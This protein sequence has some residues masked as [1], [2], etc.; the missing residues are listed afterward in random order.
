MRN[1]ASLLLCILVTQIGN[2]QIITTDPAIPIASESA[3]VYYD[4][5]LGTAG[6]KGF[7]GD[8]Y[9][10]TGVLTEASNDT[11]DWKYAPSWGD[12]APK[13]KLTRISTDYYS[14]QI[15]P[16]IREYYGVPENETITHMA[17]VFRSGDTSLEGKDDGGADIFV[18]VFEPGFN[19]SIVTP[20]KSLLVDPGTQVQFEAVASESADLELFMNDQSVKS[21]TG[22][23]ITNTFDFTT[24]GDYWLKVTATAAD[25]TDADSV[26]IHVLGSQVEQLLPEGSENGINY[27]D[28]QTVR[29]VLHAPGKENVFVIGDFN[30]WTPRSDAR[31]LRDNEHWWITLNDLEPGKEYAFQYLVDGAFRIADPYTEKVLDPWNDGWISNETYPDLKPYPSQ[32]T[33]GVTSVLQTGQTAYTW[34]NTGFIPPAKENLVIY[35]LLV[36]DFIGA[37]D[38]NTLTDTLNYFSKL[39]VNAIELMPVNEFEG[40]ESWGYNPAFYF[41]PDKYYGPAEDLKVFIDSCHGR[42]IAVIL[43]MTLNH[44]YGLSPLVQLYLNRDTYKVTPENPW[45]NVDSPNQTYSW[46][47]DF[48][49]ES[50]A[51][52]AFVDRVNHHW[53]TSYNVDG[54]RFDFTKGFTNTPGDGWAY[55]ASRISLLRRMADEIWQVNNEAY[56]IL[57]HL[58]DNSEETV[59]SND[60]MLLWGNLNYNYSQAS[61]GYNV[62]NASDFGWISYKN[63]GW[64]DPH[65]VGYMESH[66]EERMM[67]RNLENGNASGSYDVTDIFTALDRI[68]LSAAFFFTIPGPKMIW[69]FGEVGYDFS[70]DYN[71]RVGNKPIRWDYFRDATRRRVYDVFAALIALKQSE[72][73]FSTE[74]FNLDVANATK[75]IEL[76]HTDMD[77]RIIG[78]FDI[79][80]QSIDPNFSQTGTWYDYFSGESMEVSDVN[81]QISLKAGAFR[82]YTTKQLEQP[83]ITT[84]DNHPGHSGPLLAVYPN[85]AGDQ[86][87]IS[88]GK[89]ADQLRLWDLNGRLVS[90][91]DATGQVATGPGTPVPGTADPGTAGMETPGRI[92]AADLSGLAPGIYILR[93]NF[94]DGTS[95]LARVIRK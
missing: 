15:T 6:L 20:D 7:T 25:A 41:A 28:N 51:T 90:S 1:I 62:N 32:Y 37:H 95:G 66:D 84:I 69:Q 77:V 45:Y 44:S 93:A 18:E 64:N 73:A 55:D 53:L 67:F 91:F 10:H 4:A 3:T 13:Y 58:A 94:R 89:Q 72:S 59:L 8:V 61:M 63:R 48:D 26:F 70:I 21:I 12:N 14:L 39:G 40:N 92:I 49:H 71:G 57:E 81:E 19:V 78:N 82:I 86:L 54:F 42:D 56:V 30:D 46:G 5:T 83:R 60:G 36:R 47:Y 2:S 52:Q 80:T 23:A 74:D 22:S 16:S 11:R 9:A 24:P 35:E 17:F 38:W 31:M 75:R 76:N 88:T 29:L 79:V 85:P 27:I 65:V 87:Y 50:S 43:D 33:S 34:Q 68:K